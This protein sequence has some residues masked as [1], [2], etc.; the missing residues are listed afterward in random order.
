MKQN[1]KIHGEMPCKCVEKPPEVASQPL[2][3][4][5]CGDLVVVSHW[6]DFDWPHD[7]V[8]LGILTEIKGGYYYINNAK[9]GYKH[10]RFVYREDA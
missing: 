5:L 7:A 9:R 8:E 3:D 10:C 1:C 4:L 2:N 6:S